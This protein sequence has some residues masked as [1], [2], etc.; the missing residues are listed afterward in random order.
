MLD[1]D[2]DG[3]GVTSGVLAGTNGA[4]NLAA[5]V[6][7]ANAAT[8]TTAGDAGETVAF[9]HAG[10]TYVFVENGANDILVELSA[11]TGVNG[12]AL[13]GVGANVGGAGFVIIG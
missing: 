6:V 2:A 7:L 12:L 1:T 11:V 3:G 4:A 8:G 9:E 13:L 10:S 5:A